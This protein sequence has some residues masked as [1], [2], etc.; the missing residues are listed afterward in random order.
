MEKQL[1]ALFISGLL[2]LV[3]ICMA[4]TSVFNNKKYTKLHY[5]AN[6]KS[7][8]VNYFG[9]LVGVFFTTIGATLIVSLLLGK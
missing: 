9:F 3:G 8:R 1:F 4:Y 2:L 6:Q 5:L 7:N